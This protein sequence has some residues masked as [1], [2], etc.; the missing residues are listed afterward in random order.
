MLGGFSDDWILGR[1]ARAKVMLDQ[2]VKRFFVTQF[3][4]HGF[5]P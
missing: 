4:D 2:L 5:A 3:V 1:E